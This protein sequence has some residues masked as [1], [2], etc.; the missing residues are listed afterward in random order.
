[1]KR[2]LSLAALFVVLSLHT[3]AATVYTNKIEIVDG[4]L[5]YLVYSRNRGVN[6]AVG[7]YGSNNHL[8]TVPTGS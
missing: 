2:R 4:Y 3:F 7:A 1:M 6:F 5:L 8:G